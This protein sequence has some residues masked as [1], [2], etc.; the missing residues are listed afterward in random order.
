VGGEHRASGGRGRR[1]GLLLG[2][3]LA[4]DTGDVGVDGGNVLGDVVHF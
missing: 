4:V 1:D 3:A 2:A